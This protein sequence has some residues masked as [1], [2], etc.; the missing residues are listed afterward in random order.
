MSN[1]QHE[2]KWFQHICRRIAVLWRH[3]CDF[4][5]FSIVMQLFASLEEGNRNMILMGLKHNNKQ[6]MT[7]NGFIASIKMVM[8]GGMVCMYYWFTALPDL[9]GSMSLFDKTIVYPPVIRHIATENGNL[10]WVLPL[11]KRDAFPYLC[12]FTRG[13]CIWVRLKTNKHHLKLKELGRKY[14]LNRNSR[15]PWNA[16]V[17]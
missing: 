13:Y 12:S 6:P 5:R 17:G 9:L 8:T 4:H 11:K 10:S 3:S 16:L 14:Q 2:R 1:P 15:R 7:G